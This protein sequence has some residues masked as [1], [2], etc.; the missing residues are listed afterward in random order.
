MALLFDFNQDVYQSKKES[1]QMEYH[2]SFEQFSP[3]YQMDYIHAPTV[4]IESAGASGSDV[5]TKKESTQEPYAGGLT[6][7]QSDSPS[8]ST[9]LGGTLIIVS[10]VAVAGIIGYGFIKKKT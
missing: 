5:A 10:I 7:L 2:K 6:S 9:D 4:N 1:Y 8:E 3:S